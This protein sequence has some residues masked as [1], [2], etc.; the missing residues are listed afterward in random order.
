MTYAKFGSFFCDCGAKDDGTCQ[1]SVRRP[2]QL[3][4][5][6]SSTSSTTGRSNEEDKCSSAA[7]RSVTYAPY[8]VENDSVDALKSGEESNEKRRVLTKQLEPHLDE[9]LKS[10]TT[11][12]L[13]GNISAIL[14]SLLPMIEVASTHLSPVGSMQRARKTIHLL[15]H[16]PKTILA[17]ESLMIPTLG[18]Q[19]GAFENVRMSFTGD[20]GQTIRQ[21]LSAHVLRRVSMTCL[22]SVYGRRQHLA[23]SHEKGKVTVLQLNTLLKQVTITS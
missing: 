18:S 11:S 6:A 1:A 2:P 20:Q 8:R 7:C 14:K 3:D 21:L 5:E 9:L 19:E 10:L 13:I 22:S 23:M 17:S 4:E 16:D 12:Q 15:H